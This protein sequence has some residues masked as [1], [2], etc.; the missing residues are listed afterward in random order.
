M[1]C[2][3]CS[4]RM[5]YMYKPDIQCHCRGTCGLIIR[6]CNSDYENKLMEVVSLMT[7]NDLVIK[8]S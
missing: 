6:V 3:I 4:G 7:A 1:K 2:P 5:K 8:G